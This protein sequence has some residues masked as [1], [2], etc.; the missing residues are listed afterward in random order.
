[1]QPPKAS[2]PGTGHQPA[3]NRAATAVDL[4]LT[5][6]QRSR[7]HHHHP[8]HSHRHR[9]TFGSQQSMRVRCTLDLPT[10][11][12]TFSSDPECPSLT[13]PLCSG[14]TNCATSTANVCG[15]AASTSD[16]E[17]TR[18]SLSPSPHRSAMPPELIVTTAQ[19]Q[20]SCDSGR[21]CELP[22]LVAAASGAAIPR[23]VSASVTVTA[24][25]K[26]KHAWHNL[27]KCLPVQR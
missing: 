14:A 3:G 7:R 27:Q 2:K 10:A 5:D 12:P 18:A 16:D 1:M 23:A 13:F 17:R 11:E 24:A 4:L 19:P 9:S 20:P 6:M 15:G 21:D 25:L 26:H 8:H 22:P